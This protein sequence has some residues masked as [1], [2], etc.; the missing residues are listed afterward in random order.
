[1]RRAWVTVVAL[2]GLVGPALAEQWT[3]PPVL[4]TSGEASIRAVPNQ[5]MVNVATEGRAQNAKDA[6]RADAEA[7]AA[8]RKA[9]K[10]AG[11]P[12]A[13][14]R[15]LAYDLQQEFDYVS[16]KQTPRGYLARNTIE[17]RVDDVGKLGD[18]IAKIVSAGGASIAG[19]RFDVKERDQLERDA[20][21]KAVE[22]ARSRA[23]AAAAGAGTSVTGLIRIEEL[24]M[25]EP[26]PMVMARTM[27]AE[28]AAVA[29]PIAAG[30]LEIRAAVTLTSALK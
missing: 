10:E 29:T 6:Q 12:D 17:I 9:L 24:R 30:E 16:G 5:A 3:G 18:L 21:R 14:V 13:S 22:D 8:V 23:D 19:I 1:M 28:Q 20:L 26:R 4:V 2:A 7:M 11:V 25:P 15:T 27:A